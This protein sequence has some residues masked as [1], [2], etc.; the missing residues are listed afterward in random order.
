MS[1]HVDGPSARSSTESPP[2][3]AA[4]RRIG[5]VAVTLIALSTLV[6]GCVIVP[7]DYG[8]EPR[9]PRHHHHHRP[10]GW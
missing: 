10:W 7:W 2:R 4:G 1:Q 3:R 9:R 6:A 5:T 8:Y